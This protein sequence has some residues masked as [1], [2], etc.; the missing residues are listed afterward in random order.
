MTEHPRLRP[1]D[2]DIERLGTR[3]YLSRLMPI[4]QATVELE[5]MRKRAHG[6]PV[7]KPDENAAKGG[8]LERL[9]P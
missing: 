9:S 2:D 5:L 7:S 3:E 6:L 8:P 1:Q 4:M